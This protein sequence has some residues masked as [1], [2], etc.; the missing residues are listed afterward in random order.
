MAEA[1]TRKPPT[2]DAIGGFDAAVNQRSKGIMKYLNAFVNRVF[3]LVH[4]MHIERM[5]RLM[6]ESA[7]IGDWQGVRFY[8]DRWQQAMSL[9]SPA[10][11]ARMSRRAGVSHG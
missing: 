2:V 3:D 5:R 7:D 6:C 1:E 9:R 4:E 8:R 11:M 10:Q